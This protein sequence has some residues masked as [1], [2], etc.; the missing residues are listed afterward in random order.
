MTSLLSYRRGH[1][2]A[3]LYHHQQFQQVADAD[4]GFRIHRATHETEQG[5]L[6]KRANG[7]YKRVVPVNHRAKQRLG[8][9]STALSSSRITLPK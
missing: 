3:Y 6:Q 7:K 5:D 4:G 9:V 1:T 2:Q 8:A